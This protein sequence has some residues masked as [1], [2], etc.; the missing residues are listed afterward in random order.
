MVGKDKA[1]VLEKF[2]TFAA[3]EI[4]AKNFDEAARHPCS[5]PA[6]NGNAF[7]FKWQKAGD[8]NANRAKQDHETD[9]YKANRCK[10]GAHNYPLK[11]MYGWSLSSPHI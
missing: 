1:V 4:D 3:L 7:M 10:Y 5:H 6:R 2:V 9:S 11:Y 8:D